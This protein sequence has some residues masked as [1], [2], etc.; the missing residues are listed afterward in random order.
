MA[1]NSERNEDWIFPIGVVGHAQSYIDF[2][3]FAERGLGI[4]TRYSGAMKN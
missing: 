4:L 3:E 2:P 1:A